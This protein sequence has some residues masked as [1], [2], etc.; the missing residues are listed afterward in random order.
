MSAYLLAM[1]HADA[2]P[3]VDSDARSERY[4]VMVSEHFADVWRFLRHV[5]VGS[6]GVDDAAQDVFLIAWQRLEQIR[7]G[8][9]HAFLFTTA[10]RRAQ[11]L[12]R[13]GR[14]E[15]P[16]ENVDATLDESPTPE[17]RLDDKQ[18]CDLAFRLLRGLEEDLRAVF[19]LYELEGFT[20]QRISE[21]IEVPLGTVASRLRRAREIF[22]AR[23]SQ[24]KL[25]CRSRRSRRAERT[26]GARG[27][28][29]LERDCRDGS[30]SAHA[31]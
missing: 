12:R 28:K 6:H 27:A 1:T 14:R 3:A 22:Q 16:D 18:S 29:A 17:E 15:T 8:S 9:E 23:F 7:P 26:R 13:R 11:S 30:L 2:P 4:R 24:K 20:M 21:L 31:R 5:G 19:V 25:L 10:Y